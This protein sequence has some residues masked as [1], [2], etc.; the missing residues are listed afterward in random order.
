MYIRKVIQTYPKISSGLGK[1]IDKSNW[2][3]NVLRFFKKVNLQKLKGAC[4]IQVVT[5]FWF[6]PAP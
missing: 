3:N 5:K 2:I 4:N 6:V 1:V